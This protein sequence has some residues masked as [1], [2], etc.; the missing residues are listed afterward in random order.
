VT[1]EFTVTV[2]AGDITAGERKSHLRCPVA[3]AL[4]RVLPPG[5]RASAAF[6]TVTWFNPGNMLRYAHNPLVTYPQIMGA[7]ALPHEARKFISGYDGGYPVEP[8]EFTVTFT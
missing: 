2:T 6:D 3:L 7:C 8:L 5:H 4:N 1:H